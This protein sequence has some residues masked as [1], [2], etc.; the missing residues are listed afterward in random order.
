M[1]RMLFVNGS[2]NDIP[3]IESAHRLGYYVITSGNDPN[4]EGHG[5]SDEY[6][7]CDYSDKEA[8]LRLA[9]EKDI[10]AICSCGNDFG[11]T[12]AAYV[13]EKIGLPG[14]DSY[15]TSKT[16]HEK[17][18]FKAIVKELKLSSPSS[19]MFD[20]VDDAINYAD[21]MSFPKIIKPVDL[22][23]GKGISVAYNY[24]E[25]VDSINDAFSKSKLKHVVIEDYII[26]TQHGF[27]CYIRDKKVIFD[28]S[29]NDYSYLNPYMVWIGTGYPADGYEKV[30]EKII[31]DVERMAQHMDMADGFLTIQYMMK[32]GTPYYIETMRRCL[33]NLHFKCISRDCGINLYDLFIA[34]EAGLDCSSYIENIKSTGF[35]SGFMGIYANINGIL[36]SIIIKKE[37]ENKIF[38]KMFLYKKGDIINNYLEEKLG[39]IWFSF[40]NESE[41]NQFIKN[42]DTMIEI[43]VRKDD[44]Q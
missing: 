26:G 12:T 22:G 11:A 29:T 18:E 31:G 8:M 19:V 30:R 6:C 9:K 44:K 3:L 43:I 10:D 21:T 36:D 15:L 2:Y 1:K 35:M 41:R 37:F 5:F 39:M 7:P 4:G 14:H 42:R 13:S 34:T 24:D 20:S 25:A 38:D 23:G 27:I 40:D 17:D 16:F 33:G 32:D 28:Y